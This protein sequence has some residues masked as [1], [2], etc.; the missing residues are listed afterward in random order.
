M[1]DKSGLFREEL[2]RYRLGDRVKGT[3]RT[4]TT[5]RVVVLSVAIFSTTVRC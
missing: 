4:G 3:K 2:D 5:A 1:G